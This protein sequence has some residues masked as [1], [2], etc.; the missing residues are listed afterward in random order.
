[1]DSSVPQA[2][3]VN[4]QPTFIQKKTSCI[5]MLY[6]MSPEIKI[7]NSYFDRWT[8]SKQDEI[9]IFSKKYN[10]SPDNSPDNLKK[11][12]DDSPKTNDSYKLRNSPT[13]REEMTSDSDGDMAMVFGELD[14]DMTN[15]SC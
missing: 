10:N 15:P 5:E 7:T 11:P 9:D 1:M 13:L 8:T 14:I 3:P 6:G 12:R 4:N 2:I